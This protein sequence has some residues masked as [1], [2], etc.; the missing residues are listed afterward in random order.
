VVA[1]SDPGR[2]AGMKGTLM[3][4]PVWSRSESQPE[5][6]TERRPP[7]PL[8][9]RPIRIAPLAGDADRRWFAQL[10]RTAWGGEVMVTRGRT[11]RLAEL[12]A[13]LAWVGEDRVGAATYRLDE[14]EAELLSLST[15]P[16]GCGIGSALLVAVEEAMRRT[17]RRRL[18]L[19]T[20]NDNVDAL[21]FY[22]RRD[23]R[24][25]ALFPGAVDAARAGKPT[26]SCLGL[27]SIPIHDELVLEKRL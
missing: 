17:G 12:E 1:H 8:E 16:H 25:I 10:W 20:T 2:E 21:R 14:D 9:P 7:F 5:P 6:A 26:I 15:I 13:L 22:Q 11:H 18:W 27:H 19:V 3:R 23:Y 4:E 24:L